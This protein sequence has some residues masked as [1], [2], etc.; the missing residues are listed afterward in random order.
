MLSAS[1]WVCAAPIHLSETQ[2]EGRTLITVS[3]AHYVADIAPGH[4]GRITAL[5]RPGS[6]LH[7]GTFADDFDP[8]YD[9][10]DGPA[11]Y[12]HRIVRSDETLATIVCSCERTFPPAAHA[13]IWRKTFTFRADSPS[14]HVLMEIAPPRAQHVAYG[15]RNTIALGGLP[16]PTR[17]C[18]VRTPSEKQSIDLTKEN[19]ACEHWIK[20]GD[21]CVAGL[22]STKTGQAI[23]LAASAPHAPAY[24]YLR[25]DRTRGEVLLDLSFPIRAASRD[26]PYR[27]AWHISLLDSV[28][29]A[30]DVVQAMT[31]AQ[32]TGPTTATKQMLPERVAR[33]PKA[34]STPTKHHL[35][36]VEPHGRRG[37]YGLRS[38]LTRVP[39]PITITDAFCRRGTYWPAENE[40]LLGVP[41]SGEEWAKY[42]VAVFVDVPGWA[43][44]PGDVS[45]LQEYVKQGGNVV[46]VGGHGRGNR[47]TGLSEMIPAK[48]L[49]DKFAAK[50]AEG[51]EFLKDRSPWTN[52]VLRGFKHPFLRG[53]PQTGLPKAVVHQVTPDNSGEVLMAAGLY[54]VLAVRQLGRGQVVSMPIALSPSQDTGS[55]LRSDLLANVAELEDTFT[56]WPF[57]DD[58]WRQMV[59]ALCG[60]APQ[61]FF[62]GLS[63]QH[64]R[65]VTVPAKLAFEYEI[66][67]SSDQKL[68]VEVH[69][70]FWRDG[71]RLT[72]LH[73]KTRFEVNPNES[74][75][76]QTKIALD[77]LRGRYRYMISIR[78]AKG[79]LI[80]WRDASFL[81]LPETYLDIDLPPI[82][83][84]SPDTALPV[85]I[86]VHNIEQE[87]LLV[88]AV[89]LDDT[90]KPVLS[91]E[92]EKLK[93]L[94][95]AKMVVERQVDGSR[96]T[97]G[98][99]TVRA[100][101]YSGKNL[102]HEVDAVSAPFDMLPR[103]RATAF[104]LVCT[105]SRQP[106]VAPDVQRALQI[107][108]AAVH[109]PEMSSGSTSFETLSDRHLLPTVAAAHEHRLGIVGQCG[110][111]SRVLSET[112]P[113]ELTAKGLPPGAKAALQDYVR[114]R[115]HAPGYFAVSLLPPT[116]PAGHPPCDTCRETFRGKFGYDLPGP[117]SR[118]RYCHA[119]RFARDEATSA[120]GIVSEAIKEAA[121]LWWRVALVDP[122]SYFTGAFDP[123]HFCRAFDVVALARTSSATTRR[124]WL[125]TLRSATPTGSCRLW[126]YADVRPHTQ[127]V[128]LT[129][130]AYDTLGRGVSGLCIGAAPDPMTESSAKV[131]AGLL[132]EIKDM[133]QLL[134]SLRRR[135]GGVSLLYPL[136]SLMFA[137][138]KGVIESLAATRDA[139]E[140]ACGQVHMLHEAAFED[141]DVLREAKHVVLVNA[142][143][144]PDRLAKTFE[145][146]VHA[147][148][149]LVTIGKVGTQDDRRFPSR[150]E[151]RVLGVTY[152]DFVSAQ[153]AGLGAVPRPGVV[154]S[155]VDARAVHRY[156][157]GG[158]AVTQKQLGAGRAVCFGFVPSGSEL[159]RVLNWTWPSHLASSPQRGV[160]VTTLSDG[161]SDADYI[162]LTNRSDE[163]DTV[164]VIVPPHDWQPVAFDLRSG[165]PIALKVTKTGLQG[166]LKIAPGRGAVV[167]VFPTKPAKLLLEA[168]HEAQTLQYTVSIR[169]ASDTPLP[170]VL[171]VELVVIDPS[172]NL[173]P[174]YGGVLP[175]VSGTLQHSVQF[176]ADRVKGKCTCLARLRIG[177]LAAEASFTIK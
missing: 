93:S 135:P 164:Q 60:R 76:Q 41:A 28:H 154:L 146:W 7:L 120:I 173:R 153:V 53:L 69:I 133:G 83:A 104:P 149:T 17:S 132:A 148:G 16:G 49:Y 119:L 3:T 58:L 169:D 82:A 177:D 139:I 35:L 62:S 98:P 19:G 87:Q 36:I 81:A 63:A 112:C 72:Q 2:R 110:Q 59:V 166:E 158:A 157:A 78:D 159:K 116:N 18:F 124:L 92:D 50:D 144:L 128:G 33:V 77:G 21:R 151:E 66:E 123:T 156:E 1:P 105:A 20:P 29:S 9:S 142:F 97:R 174:E 127:A 141:E 175:V 24:L 170:Y 161:K 137:D 45:R 42:S 15:T 79:T 14:I 145:K 162:V 10:K 54:P 39:V 160:R 130:D 168:Q 115:S 44:T 38:A 155:L 136:T 171:P 109:V 86:F 40:F 107:G 80:D 43:F 101:L 55:L 6:V 48:A 129:A 61:V 143:C 106:G 113:A 176:P 84:L 27:A 12:T 117:D 8:R 91:L 75:G 67:N 89:V 131:T 68:P 37:I 46:F 90:G 163:S 95:L 134:N 94:S 99:H 140:E 172:G 23:A 11:A 32:G 100:S 88:K 51:R 65:T 125:D 31:E 102:D 126:S 25:P 71:H 74:V 13:T 108:A 5:R 122:A 118:D 167:G 4:G 52:I 56:Q 147:G 138:P 34:R 47:D 96:L 85:R 114:T 22:Q 30:D 165:E 150:F 64:D 152:G 70:D 111:A 26:R 121:P 73:S 103:Y 57:Y